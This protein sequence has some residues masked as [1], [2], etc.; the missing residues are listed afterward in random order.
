MRISDWSSDVC[1]SDLLAVKLGYSDSTELDFR[2]L[3]LA[4]VV[5]VLALPL[6]T[7]L[8]ILRVPSR[9][10]AAPPTE[11]RHG[12]REIVAAV[13]NNPPL[14]RLLAAFI[15][16]GLLSGMSAGVASFYIDT[17]LNLSKQFPAK[18]GRAQ[19]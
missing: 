7:A 14:L 1:S 13:R 18:I 3:G 10:Q 5:C 4:A 15:P 6:T 19:V 12:F 16:V 2:S 9:V 11:E 17:Y 8:L